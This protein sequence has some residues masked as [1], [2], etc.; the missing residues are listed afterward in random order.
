[1]NACRSCFFFMAFLSTNRSE[2][3][4]AGTCRRNPP[5][6]HPTADDND[7]SGFWPSVS[8]DDWCGEFV[9][10]PTEEPTK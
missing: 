9:A 4:T 8:G 6:I 5:I 2:R 10:A 7:F 1:M 3:D